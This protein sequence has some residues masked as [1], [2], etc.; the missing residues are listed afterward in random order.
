MPCH[1]PLSVYITWGQ[2]GP[3]LTPLV[4]QE[5]SEGSPPTHC[6]Q[7]RTSRGHASQGAGGTWASSE[8][9]WGVEAEGRDT[10]ALGISESRIL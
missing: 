10:Y 6:Q 9:G 4:V 2:A 1:S 8:Y 3:V 7:D 5:E